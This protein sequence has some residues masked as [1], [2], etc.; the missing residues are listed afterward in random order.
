MGLSFDVTSLLTNIPIVETCNTLFNKCFHNS[1][2]TFNWFTQDI[3]SKVLINC[4]WNNLFMINEELYVHLLWE[5]LYIFLCYHESFWLYTWVSRRIW[6]CI[7]V[8]LMIVSFCSRANLISQYFFYF[9][10]NKMLL[11]NSP[12]NYM[13]ITVFHF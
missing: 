10:N 6:A 7:N 4:I 8:T 1:T 9:L 5:E 12:V 2:S 13:I 11:L 3:F